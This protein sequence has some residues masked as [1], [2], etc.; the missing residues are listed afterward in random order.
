MEIQPKILF[1][2][3]LPVKNITGEHK[4]ENRLRTVLS[5]KFN[6]KIKSL[7]V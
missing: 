3:P 7:S 6:L 2:Y 5:E 4:Y 1:L